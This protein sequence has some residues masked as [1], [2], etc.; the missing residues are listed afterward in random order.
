MDGTKLAAVVTNLAVS[1]ILVKFIISGSKIACCMR[2]VV[3]VTL[4]P[5][6]IGD[7]E[8]QDEPFLGELVCYHYKNLK[9]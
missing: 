2:A 3:A 9:S 5:S 4:L 6:N 8:G 7:K 1:E